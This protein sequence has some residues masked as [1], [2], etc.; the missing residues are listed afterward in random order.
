MESF[1]DKIEVREE[2]SELLKLLLESRKEGLAYMHAIVDGQDF[3]YRSLERERL[4]HR[5]YSLENSLS[6]IAETLKQYVLEC[7]KLSFGTKIQ[8]ELRQYLVRPYIKEGLLDFLDEIIDDTANIYKLEMD[9]SNNLF[10]NVNHSKA[11]YKENDKKENMKKILK[12]ITEI[13]YSTEFVSE[14]EES[15]DFVKELKIITYKKL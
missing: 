14:L 13:E 5:K 1:D 8:N 4:K 3:N 6:S 7:D 12:E 10:L 15:I 9:N 2:A 11:F